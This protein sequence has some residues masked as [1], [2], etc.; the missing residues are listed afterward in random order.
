MASNDRKEFQAMADNFL[1]KDY[2]GGKIAKVSLLRE[3]L[4][5][6]QSELSQKLEAG[7]LSPEAYMDA[8]TKLLNRTFLDCEQILGSKDFEKLFG[9]PASEAGHLVDRRIFLGTTH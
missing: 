4:L 3:E 9:I 7:Q 2:S 1:G 6:K 8:L 5:N